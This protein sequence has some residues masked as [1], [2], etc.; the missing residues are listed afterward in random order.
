MDAVK[1]TLKDGNEYTFSDVPIGFFRRFNAAAQA[2]DAG[3]VQDTG[4]DIITRSLRDA[5]PDLTRQMV[6]D[7]LVSYVNYPEALNAALEASGAGEIRPAAN[8]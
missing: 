2:A 1:R 7:E 6:E 5:H 8:S 3:A 4:L